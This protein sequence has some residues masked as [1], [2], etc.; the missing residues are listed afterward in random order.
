MNKIYNTLTVENLVKTEWINQF[1]ENQQKEILK[2]IEANI[3]V[4]IYAKPE[5]NS[6]YMATIREGLEDNLDV[7]F[8]ADYAFSDS[9]MEQIRKAIKEDKNLLITYG[10][11]SHEFDQKQI[12]EIKYIAESKYSIKKKITKD[13]FLNK[14]KKRIVSFFKSLKK[15]KIC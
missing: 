14:Q 1:D 8:Y 11:G 7:V 4:L 9:Q 3:D 2:G 6:K 10:D 12:E 15:D 5:Y 13:S